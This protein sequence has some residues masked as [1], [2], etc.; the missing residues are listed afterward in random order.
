M[1][2]H[3]KKCGKEIPSD[4]IAVRESRNI[5]NL[6]SGKFWRDYHIVCTDCSEWKMPDLTVDEATLNRMQDFY[7]SGNTYRDPLI[8]EEGNAIDDEWEYSVKAWTREKREEVE[9]LYPEPCEGCGRILVYPHERSRHVC[10]IRCNIRA[11][12]PPKRLDVTWCENCSEEFHPK[13]SDQ[14]YCSPKCRVAA[15]RFLKKHGNE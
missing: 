3:C 13:R 7:G 11:C 6:F 10:N 12:Q 1:A 9:K 5:R 8:D 4:E 2:D 15:H 14:K